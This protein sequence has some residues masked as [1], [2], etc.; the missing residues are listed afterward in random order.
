[1]RHGLLDALKRH[2]SQAQQPEDVPPCI[3]S[4]KNYIISVYS[5]KLYYVAVLRTEGCG[6]I[7]L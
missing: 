1:M 2:R 3:V 5:N 6:C 4:G 7:F